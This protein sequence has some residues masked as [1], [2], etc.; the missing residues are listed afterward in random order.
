MHG[1]KLSKP[2]RLLCPTKHDT[3]TV[4]TWSHIVLPPFTQKSM[5]HKSSRSYILKMTVRS[6]T[7]DTGHGLDSLE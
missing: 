2:T 7:S 6:R 3:Q 5:L 4:T 1:K